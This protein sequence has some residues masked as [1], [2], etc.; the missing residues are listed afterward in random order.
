VLTGS[1]FRPFALW[2]EPGRLWSVLEETA[3]ELGAETPEKMAVTMTAELADCFETKRTG[4]LF[5]LDAFSRAFP[6]ADLRIYGVDGRFR[7]SGEARLRPREVAA[8]NWMASASLAA[9]EVSDAVF[10]DV[11][12]TTT[13]IIPIV[14]GRVVAEGRS[15]ETR[16]SAGELVYTGVLRTPVCAAVRSVPLRGRMCR[17]AA[18]VFA[19][20]ADAHLWLGQIGEADYSC[21]TPDGRG[22]TRHE[23]GARLARMV[24]ADLEILDEDDLTSIARHVDRI[25]VRQITGG[26]RQVLRRLRPVRPSVAVLAGPGTFLSGRAAMAA[27]LT[28]TADASLCGPAASSCGP[29]VAVARLLALSL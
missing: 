1:A 2:R 13:D 9:R 15:D 20:A 14:D 17:V 23:A 25:Q 7:S 6:R 21:E 29:A 26:L 10:M 18:E 27:G 22:R 28:P 19:V 24:C 3:R 11:G 4:V 8:A 12:S 16:L 5:V